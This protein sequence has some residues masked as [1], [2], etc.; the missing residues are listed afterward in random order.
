M[1]RLEKEMEVCETC[2]AFLVVND[3]AKRLDA[4][5]EGKQHTGYEKVRNELK[6]LQV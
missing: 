1:F 6:R 2:G 5:F 4:H 3:A